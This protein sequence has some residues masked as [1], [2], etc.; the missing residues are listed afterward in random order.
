MPEFDEQDNGVKQ[1]RILSPYLFNTFID[2]ITDPISKGNLYAPT[3]ESAMIPALL[4]F[5]LMI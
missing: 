2:D 3:I 5:V 1:G 4:A